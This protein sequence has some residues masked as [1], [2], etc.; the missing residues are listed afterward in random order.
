MF[1]RQQPGKLDACILYRK[2]T[3][4]CRVVVLGQHIGP[5]A[6]PLDDQRQKFSSSDVLHRARTKQLEWVI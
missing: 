5:A 1:L 3:R 2:L 4:L 6:R